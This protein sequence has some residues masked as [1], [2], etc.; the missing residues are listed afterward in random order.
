MPTTIIFDTKFLKYETDEYK[1]KWCLLRAIEWGQ[2]PLFIAQ[3]IAPLILLYASWK[4]LAVTLIVLTW[5]W[6]RIRMR[7]VSLS[8]AQFGS[9]FVHLKWLT[10]I[11]VCG[12]FILH[13]NYKLAALAILWPLVTLIL[14]F[15]VPP[16][17][18]GTLQE[19][20]AHKVISQSQF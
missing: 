14:Q 3:P 16:T 12:Y 13:D 11:L 20:F 18:I 6:S 17:Q 2:W 7:F 4:Q 10:G 15:L 8:L 19:I 1:A 5:L 9:F